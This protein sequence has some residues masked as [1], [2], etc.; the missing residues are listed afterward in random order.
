MARL[1]DGRMGEWENGNQPSRRGREAENGLP[2]I[3]L[4]GLIAV[5]VFV[6]SAFT[7]H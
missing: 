1:M 3:D 6:G 4:E 7:A 2:G 5:G